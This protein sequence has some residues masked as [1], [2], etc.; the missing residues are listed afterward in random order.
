M[1]LLAFVVALA[2][3]LQAYQA[4]EAQRSAQATQI[5]LLG[6]QLD[7]QSEM[8][9]LQAGDSV[10][11]PAAT[12]AAVRVVELESTAVTLATAQA[13]A[14]PVVI[15]SDPPQVIRPLRDHHTVSIGTSVFTKATFSDGMAPYDEGWLW[16]NDHFNIQRIR[17][18]ENP[19]GCGSVQYQVDRIWIG[20]AATAKVTVNGSEIGTITTITPLQ[21][22]GYIVGVRLDVGDVIC[23]SP[24]PQSGFQII[25]GPDIY[26]HHD[27]YCYRGNC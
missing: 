18:E 19:D 8:A 21:E 1:A 13:E 4:A 25:F 6:R 16:T 27:S 24:I 22:H 20:V 7:V 23:V 5:A 3:L 11:G 26:Y 2:Q 14:E 9:T 10:P 15:P 17:R 12:A